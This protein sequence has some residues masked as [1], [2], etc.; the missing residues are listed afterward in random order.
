M[1][2]HISS[3]WFLFHSPTSQISSTLTE[4]DF[5]VVDD[6]LDSGSDFFVG[7]AVHQFAPGLPF[8]RIIYSRKSIWVRGDENPKKER[9]KENS[10]SYLAQGE[11]K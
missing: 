11:L 10:I 3:I 6:S 1:R 7:S 5:L 9:K 2:G 8:H 4:V